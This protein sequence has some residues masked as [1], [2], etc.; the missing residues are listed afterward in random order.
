[1]THAEHLRD[2][3]MNRALTLLPR[4][5]EIMSEA[6]D[7]LGEFLSGTAT[8]AELLE[9]LDDVSATA[10]ADHIQ[11]HRVLDDLR[12]DVRLLEGSL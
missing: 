6:A 4:P 1:M 3:W 7:R 10:P 2:G 12:R 8:L 11:S 5:C 9:W